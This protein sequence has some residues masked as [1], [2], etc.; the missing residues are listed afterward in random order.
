MKS[1]QHHYSKSSLAQQR[2]LRDQREGRSRRDG[3][4][5]QSLKRLSKK[6]LQLG[7]INTKFFEQ[8]SNTHVVYQGSFQR[9]EDSPDP[10]EHQIPGEQ[11]PA[12]VPEDRLTEAEKQKLIK[13]IDDMKQQIMSYQ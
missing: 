4:N 2:E 1:K 12:D 10:S 5:A 7:E 9:R 3:A 13:K 6:H 8:S 11:D